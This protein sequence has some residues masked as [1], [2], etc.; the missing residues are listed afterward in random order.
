MKTIHIFLLLLF[1]P[2]IS[3]GQINQSIDFI[4]GLDYSYRNLSGGS[5]NPLESNLI[6]NLAN[7]E[8]GK[9]NWRF[10]TNYNKRLNKKVFLKTGFRIAREGF[11]ARTDISRRL[12]RKITDDMIFP[13]GFHKEIYGYNFWFLEFPIAARFEINKKKLSPFFELGLAPSYYVFSQTRFST[14]FGNKSHYFRENNSDF[15]AFHLLAFASF[16]YNYSLNENL[17]LFGQTVFR[18]HLTSSRAGPVKERLFTAGLE[19]GVRKNL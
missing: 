16:G 1:I 17:Q 8:H 4:G 10:G 9:L 7:E 11:K 3:F 15:N 13:E 5:D 12:G 14:E 2:F 6:E 19:L 18:Y